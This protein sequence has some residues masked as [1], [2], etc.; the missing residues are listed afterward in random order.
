MCR[1]RRQEKKGRGVGVNRFVSNIR[2]KKSEKSGEKKR[3]Y[4]NAY[5]GEASD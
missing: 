2:N 4:A 3:N 5:S 1:K